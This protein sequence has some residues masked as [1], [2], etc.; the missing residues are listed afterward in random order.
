MKKI[1]LVIVAVVLCAAAV[2]G[3]AP[4]SDG[5]ASTDYK[6]W[7]IKEWTAADDAAKTAATEWVLGEVGE[8]LIPNFSQ[9]A[10]QAKKDDAAKEQYSEMVEGLKPQIESFLNASEKATLQDLADS[11]SKLGEA[12]SNA[13]S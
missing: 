12:Y 5:G 1:V 4:Q 7:T 10:E 13:L 6:A 2:M 11:S 9:V 8:A 3:C